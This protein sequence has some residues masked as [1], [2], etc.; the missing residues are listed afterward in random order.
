MIL[1]IF[2]KK[3]EHSIHLYVIGKAGVP[4][5]SFLK[6]YFRFDDKVF[7]ICFL[8]VQVVYLIVRVAQIWG[9]TWVHGYCSQSLCHYLSIFW[10]SVCHYLRHKGKT[11]SCSNNNKTYLMKMQ[12]WIIID[13]ILVLSL[14]K[15]S[16]LWGVSS[17][18]TVAKT[19]VSPVT[20]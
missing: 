8:L 20:V 4:I 12:S 7:I 18:R 6:S 19:P 11:Y 14:L 9:S 15:T 1:L 5:Y 16:L 10:L 17:V 2:L 3:F 13:H